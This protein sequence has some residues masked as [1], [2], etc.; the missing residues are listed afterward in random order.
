V[1]EDLKTVDTH[2]RQID[3]DGVNVKGRLSD[4]LDLDYAK[5]I[6]DLN[7]NQTALDAAMK[8]YSQVSKMSLF[9]YL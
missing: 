9:Q 1:G 5:A 3:A 4:L 8:T 6:T 7:S 2:S